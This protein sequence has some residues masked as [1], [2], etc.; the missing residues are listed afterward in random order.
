METSHYALLFLANERLAH[1]REAAAR[2]ALV[3]SVTPRPVIRLW[4]GSA[5]VA[6][7]QRL[8]Q[9]ERAPQRVPS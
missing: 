3:A 6:L 4:L 5:L 2:R 9:D 1:A 7:G 8:L